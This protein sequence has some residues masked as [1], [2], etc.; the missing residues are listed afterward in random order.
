MNLFCAPNCNLVPVDPEAGE[1]NA[2]NGGGSD[3][4]GHPVSNNFNSDMSILYN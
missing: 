3:E 2:F 1:V 4:L